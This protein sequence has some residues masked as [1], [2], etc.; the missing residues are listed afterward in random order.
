MTP[1]LSTADL[2]LRPMR[3]ATKE[4]V[5]LLNTPE[6]VRLSENRHHFHTFDSCQQYIDSIVRNGGHIWS[7][8]HVA[9]ADF[10]GTISAHMDTNNNVADMGIRIDREWTRE[11]YGTQAWQRVADWLLSDAPSG[12]G[13]RKLEAGCAA[14]NEGMKRILA[15]SKFQFE[16]ERKLH[17]L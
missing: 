9:G 3:R 6:N 10:I 4:Q 13:V 8:H 5:K 14:T 12:A 11:G 2:V 7:I 16:G 15:H 1:T 17:F